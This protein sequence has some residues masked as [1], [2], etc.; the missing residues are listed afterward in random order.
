VFY[1]EVFY[2][3]RLYRI[4]ASSHRALVDGIMHVMERD[5]PL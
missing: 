3:V 5:D 4:L 1:E 2:E